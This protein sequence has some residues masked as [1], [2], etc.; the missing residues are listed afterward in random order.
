MEGWILVCLFDH[1][2]INICLLYFQSTTFKSLILSL[3]LFHGVILERRRFGPLGFNI[4][5][6]FTDGDL[7]ICMS[8][9]KMF[10]SEYSEIPFKVLKYTAGHINYGG[11]V[12]DDHD[13]RCLM[14]ILDDFYN[15]K[16]FEENFTYSESKIYRQISSAQDHNVGRLLFLSY[17]LSRLLCVYVF[18]VS[19]TVW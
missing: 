2:S 5:Y 9:L 12:T 13:R 16:I 6:E 19:L 7:K 1:L 4:P 10:L 8:Q 3:C 11:R 17:C 14:T 15:S 18:V